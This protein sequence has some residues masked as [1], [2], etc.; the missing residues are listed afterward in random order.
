MSGGK[1][2]AEQPDMASS[3][4]RMT[5]NENN[6][7][8]SSTGLD[9]PVNVDAGQESS[10]NVNRPGVDIGRPRSS[11]LVGAGLSSLLSN[12]P[13]PPI[14]RQLLSR[15][16]ST[17]KKAYQEYA[18]KVRHNESVSGEQIPT[19]P[20]TSFIEPSLFN[21]IAKYRLKK[22]K[23]LISDEEIMEFLD[24][25][26]KEDESFHGQI[27]SIIKEHAKMDLKLMPPS[28][29]LMDLL[30][31]MDR[32]IDDHN[33]QSLFE[34]GIGIQNWIRWLAESLQP[35]NFKNHKLNMIDVRKTN[36]RNNQPLFVDQLFVDI[37]KYESEVT[38]IMSKPK[39][40]INIKPAKFSKK[41]PLE[42]LEDKQKKSKDLRVSSA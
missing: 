9:G 39:T 36:L 25:V 18:K 10:G 4:S 32:V 21:S 28:S 42:S 35:Y 8:Q 1:A 16:I 7:G 31:Q 3:M 12:I 26:K 5:L 14:L 19:K 13:E 17:F 11:M 33:A 34:S 38:R 40:N 41:R 24:R 6:R 30:S 2:I 29:R 37:D 23:A 20:F 15:E 27:H 22:E